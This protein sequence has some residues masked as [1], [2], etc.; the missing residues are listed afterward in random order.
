MKDFE[1]T[2]EADRAFAAIRNGL[3][4][5]SFKYVAGQQ[6]V[7]V[8]LWLVSGGL[9]RIGS[10]MNDVSDRFE[11]GVRDFVLA[12]ED[13]DSGHVFP[14][15]DTF[16]GVLKIEKLVL[17]DP[18]VQ[19]ESGIV[20]RSANGAEITIVAA[21]APYTF[22]VRGS[23]IDLAVGSPEYPLSEYSRVPL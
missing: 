21:A 12:A 10:A 7:E 6:I 15:L 19:A 3:Q 20:I 5:I 18:Q 11:V 9:V 8:C 1:F 23:G 17:E 4:E 16:A 22:S 2:G 14:L 13:E